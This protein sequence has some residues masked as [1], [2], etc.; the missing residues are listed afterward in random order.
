MHHDCGVKMPLGNL[1]IHRTIMLN[2]VLGKQALRVWTRNEWFR[3]A[4][5]GGTL[6]WTEINV[7]F[8]K[9]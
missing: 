8:G 9:S 6:E 4:L 7:K 2:F 1:R 3:T 5:S